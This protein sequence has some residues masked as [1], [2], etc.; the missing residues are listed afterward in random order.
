[1]AARLYD[2]GGRIQKEAHTHEYQN[3]QKKETVR[4]LFS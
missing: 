2:N 1:M 3:K 4:I